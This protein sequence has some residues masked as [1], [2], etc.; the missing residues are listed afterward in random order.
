MIASELAETLDGV[1]HD[2]DP[3][4]GI[5][6]SV[7]PH[8]AALRHL[9]Y[10]LHLERPVCATIPLEKWKKLDQVLGDPELFA[11]LQDV[12]IAVYILLWPSDVDIDGAEQLQHSIAE[13]CTFDMLRRKV[14]EEGD[15]GHIDVQFQTD[16]GEIWDWRSLPW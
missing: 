5:C 3:W 1:Q 16:F 11:D 15:Q 13:H 10:S 9:K 4:L 14:G 8:L 6:D 2:I 7:L 12:D